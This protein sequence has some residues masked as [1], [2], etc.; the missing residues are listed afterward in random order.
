[1]RTCHFHD[2]EELVRKD[3]PTTQLF[4]LRRYSAAAFKHLGRLPRVSWLTCSYPA[5][6]NT[7]LK[8]VVFPEAGQPTNKTISG[9]FALIGRVG[10]DVGVILGP[11]N[12]Y[13]V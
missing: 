5:G 6:R 10:E 13:S 7:P 9:F 4:P 3:K 2:T 1:M 12:T 8:S 11:E